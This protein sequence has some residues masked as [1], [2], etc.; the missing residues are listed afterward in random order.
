MT[1]ESR[2]LDHCVGIADYGTQCR[3]G[4]THILSFQAGDRSLATMEVNITD[5]AS[6]PLSTVQFRGKRDGTPPKAALAAW[7][8]LED[9]LKS[10]E[11]KL[12]SEPEKGWGEIPMENPP[13]LV[14]Q[15]IGYVPSEL[16]VNRC[17]RHLQE[18]LK[19]KAAAVK[20]VR[21]EGTFWKPRTPKEGYRWREALM[22]IR[23][24]F[25][26][27]MKERDERSGLHEVIRAAG[28][29]EE[30]DAL[31]K[32]AS[33]PSHEA[34]RPQCTTVRHRRVR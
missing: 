29:A 4:E 24:G 9:R 26:G 34:S 27:I 13:P 3:R 21:S 16:Q 10:G 22:P 30:W 2:R 8:W 5:N 31:V 32:E 17:Y 28:F 7:Q 23:E 15:T 1:E 12:N 18:S 33:I 19:I 25:N 14:V 6:A 20:D 11:E